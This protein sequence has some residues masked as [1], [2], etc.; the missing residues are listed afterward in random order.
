M[1]I[2]NSEQVGKALDILKDRLR[3]YVTGLDLL[4][5]QFNGHVAFRER[6]PGVLQVLAPLFHEDGDMVDIFLDEPVNGSGKVRIGDHGLTLMRLTYT[7][8]LDTENKQRIFNRILS[9]SRIQVLR[10]RR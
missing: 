2:T 3:P 4:K 7:Y 1:A 6:R 10:F 5:Q 9:E 8:D